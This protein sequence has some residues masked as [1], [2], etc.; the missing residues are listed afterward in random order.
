MT[1]P[2]PAQ[3]RPLQLWGGVECSVVRVADGWRDQVHETGHHQRG[4]MDL[5]ALGALGL[6]TLRY[7]L[8]W[9]RSPAQHAWHD[10]QITDLARRGIA[11]IAGL[12]H[13]GSGPAQTHLLDPAFPDKLAAHASAMATRYPGIDAWT[14]LNEP[15]T[16]AR[17]SCLYGHWHPHL[18]DEAA[19][20]YAVANQCRAILLAVRAIR[21]VNPA[22][23]FIH[24]EDIGRVFATAPLAGQARYENDRRWLSLDLL[25]GHVGADHPF[26]A[27]LEASGAPPAHLDELAT[28]EAAP[29]IVGF[30]HYATSDRFLDHRLQLYPP[31]LRGGNGHDA[32]A[33]TEALRVELGPDHTGM[34][35]R[36]R[37][38]WARYAR[39]IAITEAHLG[40]EHPEEQVRW[41]L[42]A[43]DAAH[44]LRAEGAD[45]RA[46][47]AWALFGLMDWNTMLRERRG[48]YE[49][50]AFDIRADPPRPTLLADAIAALA[51]HGHFAHPCLD[52]PGW[53][54]REDR[55]HATLRRA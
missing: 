35:P 43:W 25:C 48:H 20:L 2:G 52:E 50:G 8:L 51:Q 6:Q 7:P 55:V 27:A 10:G 31:A 11:V 38:V 40:C 30:N 42:E 22:A 53:W 28:A 54:R 16:T 44:M 23:R 14:P 45:I 17:F 37:E 47:T 13:H 24:T 46:V 26:R 3:Q 5:A 34:A 18:H 32:Y 41:L 4:A 19:F 36:L 1:P 49:P 29:D 39:P 12:V 9:E 21:A 33:D 15:L